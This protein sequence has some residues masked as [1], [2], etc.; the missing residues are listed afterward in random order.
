M[1]DLGKYAAD[2]LTAYGL[3]TLLLA[4]LLIA[5]LRAHSKA[6]ALLSQVE[7]KLKED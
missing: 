4:G 2:V 3:S 1:P 6:K 7:I 5:S